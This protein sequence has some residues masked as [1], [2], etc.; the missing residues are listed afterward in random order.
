VR[1]ACDGTGAS[2]Q[3]ASRTLL[4]NAE[5]Y[6]DDDQHAARGLARVEF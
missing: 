5:G 6:R 2:F 4:A 1:S 3:Q